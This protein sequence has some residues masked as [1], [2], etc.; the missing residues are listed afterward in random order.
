MDLWALGTDLVLGFMIIYMVSNCMRRGFIST[1][2]YFL[3][4]AVSFSLALP[5]S[6][7]SAAYLYER[8]IDSYLVNRISE[9]LSG[10]SS[11][12][13]VTLAV[14]EIIEKLTGSMGV[15]LGYLGLD[16]IEKSL[17]GFSSSISPENIARQIVDGALSAPVLSVIQSVIFVIA[18]S[19]LLFIS[20]N[21]TRRARFFSRI[22][23]VG[24]LNRFLGALIGFLEAGLFLLIISTIINLLLGFSGG[25][26][27]FIDNE[28]ISKSI[29][30]N[31]AFRYNPLI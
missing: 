16:S 23:I 30:L 29:I 12:A 2:L 22:P 13:N 3:G 28:L 7:S 17:E 15:L 6:K 4:Y 11:G 19:V 21:I 14:S 25:Q 27:L 31:A 18:F 5:F 8:F 9:S 20:R 26:F 10:I 1:V 24:P